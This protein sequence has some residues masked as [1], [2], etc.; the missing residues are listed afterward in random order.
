MNQTIVKL[1][2]L[3]VRLE[4]LGCW[5]FANELKKELMVMAKNDA[6]VFGE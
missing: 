1:Q 6:R 5:F 3:I 4:M 2:E